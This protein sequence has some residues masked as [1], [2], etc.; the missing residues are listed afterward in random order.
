VPV[1]SSPSLTRPAGIARARHACVKL[2]QSG[3]NLVTPEAVRVPELTSAANIKLNMRVS[4][5]P[6]QTSLAW[7]QSRGL[8]PQ[9]SLRTARSGAASYPRGGPAPQDKGLAVVTP[10]GLMPGLPDKTSWR[11]RVGMLWGFSAPAASLI[12]LKTVLTTLLRLGSPFD[13]TA[14]PVR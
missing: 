6:I 14:F 2:T 13:A 7:P 4:L 1:Q 5:R 12:G 3:V 8:A 11:F 10:H 9:S